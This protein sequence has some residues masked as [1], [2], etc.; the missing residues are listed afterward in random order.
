V[1]P[2]AVVVAR[3]LCTRGSQCFATDDDDDNDDNNKNNNN[4]NNNI[5]NCQCAVARWQWLLFIYI[6]VK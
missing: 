1:P 4:S 3:D 5:F 2:L 6:N